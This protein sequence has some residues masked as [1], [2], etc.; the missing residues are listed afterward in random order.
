MG[1]SI[2]YYKQLLKFSES[3]R[4]DFLKNVPKFENQLKFNNINEQC[5]KKMYQE[6]KSPEQIKPTNE[7]YD[8]IDGLKELNNKAFKYFLKPR[9][10]LVN[11]NTYSYLDENL[12]SVDP[13]QSKF[14][15][16]TFFKNIS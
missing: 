5:Y 14:Q 3:I 12:F 4:D 9:L 15:I 16:I 2:W 7:F 10:F 6:I 1:K 11:I 8:E 13:P